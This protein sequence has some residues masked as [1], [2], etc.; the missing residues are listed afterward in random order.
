MTRKQLILTAF[1]ILP[2]DAGAP[3]FVPGDLWLLRVA[4]G[5][6]SRRPQPPKHAI[7]D[8]E[9]VCLHLD[10]LCDFYH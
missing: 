7:S 4:K 10:M 6:A 9:A 3:L 8:E 1:A 5:L 2:A